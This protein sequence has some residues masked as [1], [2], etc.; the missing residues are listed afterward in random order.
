MER[1]ALLVHFA[2]AP[3]AER[4]SRL[5]FFG[6][7]GQGYIPGGEENREPVGSVFAMWGLNGSVS[8]IASDLEHRGLSRPGEETE[9]GDGGFAVCST[10]FDIEG[11]SPGRG[12][13]RSSG[14]K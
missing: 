1:G 3:H 8:V 2:G 6:D 5:K 10:D 14:K 9:I 11:V 7:R 12:G 13:Q 4:R